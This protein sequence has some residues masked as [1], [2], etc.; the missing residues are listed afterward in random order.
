MNSTKYECECE[1][2]R[3]NGNHLLVLMFG[4]T[5]GALAAGTIA[6]VI[7]LQIKLSDMRERQRN[8]DTILNIIEWNELRKNAMRNV[9][10]SEVAHEEE[11]MDDPQGTVHEN[12]EAIVDQELQ[13][14][15]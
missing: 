4:F 12:I 10:K 9:C 1:I 3:D 2:V 7:I 14:M 6:G 15:V 13:T 8:E 11:I 5:V